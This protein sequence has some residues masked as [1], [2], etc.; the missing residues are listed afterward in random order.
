MYSRK[1]FCRPSLSASRK[2]RQ[3]TRSGIWFCVC[4]WVCTDYKTSQAHWNVNLFFRRRPSLSPVIGVSLFRMAWQDLKTHQDE[5]LN[6]I[7]EDIITQEV[8]IEVIQS[9]AVEEQI[10]GGVPLLVHKSNRLNGVDSD[11]FSKHTYSEQRRFS[12]FFLFPCLFFL[13]NALGWLCLRSVFIGE[14]EG[15]SPNYSDDNSLHPIVTGLGEQVQSLF[16]V[17]NGGRFPERTREASRRKR[18]KIAKYYDW[19]PFKSPTFF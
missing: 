5:E 13:F 4:V 6:D 19:M 14:R 11:C 12:L 18:S 1:K 3:Q 16:V 15:K 7:R 2:E 10:W 9:T 8:L 17:A